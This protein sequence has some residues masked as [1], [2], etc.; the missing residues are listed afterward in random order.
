MKQ[1]PALPNA[2]RRARKYVFASFLVATVIIVVGAG[3]LGC[4]GYRVNLTPS[5]PIGLWR[6]A[7]MNAPP[8]VGDT[9]F[10][11]MPD[12]AMMR[13][14]RL[15]GY[16][17]FGLCAGRTAPLIKTVAA[18]TGQFIEVGAEVRIDG[19]LLA[20]SR[21]LAVDGRQRPLTPYA[22]GELMA[23]EVYLHSDFPGSFDSRYFGPL[24]IKNVLGLAQE[25]LT[26]AP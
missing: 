1:Q 7:S 18:L 22:G 23:G 21:L 20:H 16:L 4:G 19:R 15:R 9:L 10:V 17:R 13:E 26:Y 25:V 6:I 11:C 5:E 8:R 3:S 14:A 12:N 2:M 24:P